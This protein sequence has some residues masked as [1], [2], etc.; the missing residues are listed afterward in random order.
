MQECDEKVSIDT[1]F[2]DFYKLSGAPGEKV[3]LKP[4][5]KKV[6]VQSCSHGSRLVKKGHKLLYKV[7]FTVGSLISGPS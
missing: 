4:Q 7:Y 1:K 3:C 5:A 2:E 6:F